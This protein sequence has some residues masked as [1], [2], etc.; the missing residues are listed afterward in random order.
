MIKLRMRCS[1]KKT[2]KNQNK[3]IEQLHSVCKFDFTFRF[4]YLKDK[5][6]ILCQTNCQI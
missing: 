6:T 2:S 5:K 1:M 3:K 4:S